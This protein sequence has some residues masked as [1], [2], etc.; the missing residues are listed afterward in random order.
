MTPANIEPH[1]PISDHFRFSDVSENII[2]SDGNP[3]RRRRPDGLRRITPGAQLQGSKNSFPHF[4]TSHFSGEAGS[5][6]R[7]L[8]SQADLSPNAPTLQGALAATYCR[9][10]FAYC[11]FS[12][13]RYMCNQA[14]RRLGSL[15]IH[16][17][18]AEHEFRSSSVSG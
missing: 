14:I 12:G 11:L 18:C 1:G 15:C 10:S 8:R 6:G 2:P 5:A 16:C 3:I 9:P 17:Q 13:C 7:T 4:L